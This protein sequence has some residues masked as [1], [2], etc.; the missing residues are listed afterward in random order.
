MALAFSTKRALY[1]TARITR[2]VKTAIREPYKVGLEW[3]LLLPL[4]ATSDGDFETGL[5]KPLGLVHE[6]ACTGT[7]WP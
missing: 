1:L 3:T 7:H 4:V 5:E 2:R 6:G